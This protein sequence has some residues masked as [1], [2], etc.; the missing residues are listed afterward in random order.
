MLVIE[1]KVDDKEKSKGLR[2]IR[3]DYSTANF[4]KVIHLDRKMIGEPKEGTYV[5]GVLNIM[6]PKLKKEA[7]LP[8]YVHIH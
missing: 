4:K 6:L 5:N 2:V 3:H 7:T 8:N 1:A